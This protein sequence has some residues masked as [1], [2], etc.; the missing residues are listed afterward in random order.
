M[1]Q[2]ILLDLCAAALLLAVWRLVG[3]LM[4]VRGSS[5]LSALHHG[6]LL[7]VS[8]LAYL[9]GAPQRGDIVICHYP[10]RWIHPRIHIPQNFVKRVIAVPGDTLCCEEGVLLLNGEPLEE[11]YLDPLYTCRRLFLTPR[12]LGPDQ[13]FVM[14]DNRDNSSDSRRVGPLSRKAIIGKVTRVLLSPHAIKAR[15]AAT[16]QGGG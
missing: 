1:L 4:L 13:Y 10:R 15:R 11:P 8:R 12:T 14:G 7:A 16:R 2:Y 9:R 3:M 5:M 6:D